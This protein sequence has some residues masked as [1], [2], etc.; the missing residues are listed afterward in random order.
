MTSTA[1]TGVSVAARVMAAARAD[2]EGGPTTDAVAQRLL[3]RMRATVAAWVGV[4][5][6]DALIERACVL[7][8][9]RHVT[10]RNLRWRPKEDPPLQGLV[11]LAPDEAPLF[12]G[13]ETMII[14]IIEILSQFIGAEIAARLVVDGWIDDPDS[15]QDDQEEEP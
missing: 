14:A 10:L 13:G 7:A 6:F 8:G 5:A 12:P 2:P 15:A 11:V 9:P 1:L 3:V 4:D